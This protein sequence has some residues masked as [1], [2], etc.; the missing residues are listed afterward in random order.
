MH[1][2][3]QTYQ[4]YEKITCFDFCPLQIYCVRQFI[5]EC[6]SNKLHFTTP[7]GNFYSKNT[8][9]KTGKSGFIENK[10]SLGEFEIAFRGK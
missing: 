8:L 3:T 1:I 10:G 7:S 5:K 9:N 6:T 2:M 4:T